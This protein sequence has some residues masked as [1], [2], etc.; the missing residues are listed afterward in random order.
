M[1]DGLFGRGFTTKCKSSI[2]LI[3][4]RIDLIRRKRNATQKF[5]KKDIADLL[6][7]G[8]DTNA[9]GRAEGLLVELNLSSCYDLVEQFCDCILKEIS[10]MQK[11][12][13]CP[14]ECGEAVQSL[15]FAAARFADLPEL[16]D[17]RQL[18]AERYGNSLESFLN[19]EFSEKMAAKSH[20]RENKLQLM[21]DLAKEFSIKWDSKAFEQK[22]SNPPAYEQDRYNKQ[23]SFHDSNKGDQLQNGMDDSFPKKDI[24]D[25]SS[26]GRNEGI[27]DEYKSPT[28]G[29]REPTDDGYKLQ[30]ER[31]NNEED[32][33][34]ENYKGNIPSHARVEVTPSFTRRQQVKTDAVNG[35]VA[36]NNLNSPKNH[37]HSINKVIKEK[38]EPLRPFC[39]NIVPPPYVISRGSKYITNSEAQETSSNKNESSSDPP[40]RNRE[41][42]RNRLDRMEKRLNHVDYGDHLVEPAQV[43]GHGDE[44]DHHLDDLVGDAKPRPRSVRRHL[45][46][47]PGHDRNNSKE[48]EEDR[49]M[50]KLL[51]HYSKKKSTYEPSK[52]SNGLKAPSTH[53]T[54]ANNLQSPRQRSRDVAHNRG[55]SD[56][57]ARTVSLPPEPTTPTQGLTGHARAKSFQPDEQAG[58]V[59]PKLPDYDD[60]A[61]RIAALRGHK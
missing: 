13:E 23:G 11:Q 49:M 37:L 55:L 29:R 30:N 22:L 35:P 4:A 16:R 10:V 34:P 45:K 41:I 39:D 27:H 21:R 19:Q 50:D 25:V 38:T 28:H 42:M 32:T 9:Y 46:P 6:A 36:D 31:C 14:E 7:N 44:K 40:Y 17:L 60:L 53:E 15:K 43:N 51:L 26:R 2:K 3:K 8:L 61:A 58:H 57:P 12:R 54:A 20:T 59:H 47:P 1:L 5:L 18:F 56:P 33:L 24:Q 52:V 48:D